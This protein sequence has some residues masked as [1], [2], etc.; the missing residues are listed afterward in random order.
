MQT[1]VA[2]G[3]RDRRLDHGGEYVS[4]G[5]NRPGSIRIRFNQ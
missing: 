2:V 5:S 4:I 1:M 3:V